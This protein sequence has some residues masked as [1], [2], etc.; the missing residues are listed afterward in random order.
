MGKTSPQMSDPNEAPN[1][2]R[3]LV[4]QKT[5]ISS[6][7]HTI[8]KSQATRLINRPLQNFRKFWTN[9]TYNLLE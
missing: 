2:N 7:K 4:N 5:H 1:E 3:V 9:I 6:R 8:D